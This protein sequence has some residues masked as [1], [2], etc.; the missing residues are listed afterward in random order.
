MDKKPLQKNKKSPRPK[1]KKFKFLFDAPFD[2]P[3]AFKRL[4]KKANV[5]NIK[6]SYGLVSTTE[7][8]FIY[9]LATK[10]DRI[11]VTL[12]DDFKRLTKPK[13]AG[14]FIIP[15]YLTTEIWD[16]LLV[17]FIKG[18]DPDD[19]IGKVIRVNDEK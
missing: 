12:D 2:K 5:K 15:A 9:S 10:S 7:D 3:S 14:V 4:A 6:H 18:K 16:D 8:E 19:Y 17:K 13:Q 11:I 1:T